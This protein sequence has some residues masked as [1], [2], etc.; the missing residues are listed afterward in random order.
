MLFALRL[1]FLTTA[2]FL[3]ANV[4]AQDPDSYI[5]EEHIQGYRVLFVDV[6]SDNDTYIEAVVHSGSLQDPPETLGVAH[7]LEHIIASGSLSFPRRTDPFRTLN[8]I[9]SANAE[10]RSI[11]TLYYWQGQVD[12]L[13]QAA[14]IISSF[15]SQPEFDP[16]AIETERK[17]ILDEWATSESSDPDSRLADALSGILYERHPITKPILG[18]KNTIKRIHQQDLKDYWK[19]HYQPKNVDFIVC[20]PF[21]K[22]KRLFSSVRNSMKRFLKNREDAGEIPQ[23]KA[24]DEHWWN[25]KN[26]AISV[27]SP[28][29]VG[30]HLFLTIPLRD[31]KLHQLE[32]LKR[33]LSP[34]ESQVPGS[35]YDELRKLNLVDQVIVDVDNPPTG[36]LL[37]ISVVLNKHKE[38][39][40]ESILFISRR[41]LGALNSIAQG[42]DISRLLDIDAKN[43]R[44]QAKDL[45]QDAE[46]IAHILR[47]ALFE[48]IDYKNYLNRY[49]EPQNLDQTAIRNIFSLMIPEYM[50]ST[51]LRQSSQKLEQSSK[52][53]PWMSYGKSEDFQLTDL[54]QYLATGQRQRN[55]DPGI[56][57]PEALNAGPSL[58]PT[59]EQKKKKKRS[60]IK[61]VDSLATLVGLADFK[62][63]HAGIE[64]ILKKPA[65]SFEEVLALDLLVETWNNEQNFSQWTWMSELTGLEV[66]SNELEDQLELRLSASGPTEAVHLVPLRFVQELKSFKIDQGA[67]DRT[68]RYLKD[69]FDDLRQGFAANIAV[70][71]SLYI[72]SPS[73]LHIFDR[74]AM[75]HE[76]KI[77]LQMVLDIQKRFF[78]KADIFISAA[79]NTDESRLTHLAAKLRKLVPNELTEGERLITQK[80]TLDALEKINDPISVQIP[81]HTNGEAADESTSIGMAQS[82]LYKPSLEERVYLSLAIQLISDSVFAKNRRFGYIQEASMHKLSSNAS[83]A[84]MLI[85]QTGSIEKLPAIRKGWENVRR[86]LLKPNEDELENM[87]N[88]ILDSIEVHK[89]FDRKWNALAKFGLLN[90]DR[91]KLP[92]IPGSAK[93]IK[94]LKQLHPEEVFKLAVKLMTLAPKLTVIV[95]PSDT[96]IPQEALGSCTQAFK[97]V[98]TLTRAL[99]EGSKLQ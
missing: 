95:A 48:N 90:F 94:I 70:E 47:E 14:Q 6:D 62:D 57:W 81:L 40:S 8:E 34:L 65:A 19:L 76:Q 39:S 20:A 93:S 61:Q 89:T 66:N 4:R 99:R 67:L 73:H 60:F 84:F 53:M 79:G 12:K 75:F 28:Q 26:S 38:M 11:G 29:L 16:Y 55:S 85:S 68:Y 52:E 83:L 42:E 32:D 17:A 36:A 15:V 92:S 46:G 30:N 51:L 87:K 2:L 35:P 80:S 96:P 3:S 58:P 91:W 23:I 98:T 9:G 64:L 49:L 18:N 7:F 54:R 59:E 71:D 78:E 72:L 69:T 22:N 37:H 74:R 21:S 77:S 44:L 43:D 41:L 45:K 27:H 24:L 56:S 5:R 1:I 31:A 10:T 33:I 88:Q 82:S 97:D 63:E 50:Q 13:K 25:V 86:R